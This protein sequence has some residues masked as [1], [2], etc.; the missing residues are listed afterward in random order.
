MTEPKQKYEPLSEAGLSE[1]EARLAVVAPKEPYTREIF[2]FIATI[3]AQQQEIGRLRSWRREAIP[4]LQVARK[5]AWQVGA[6]FDVIAI[7]NLITGKED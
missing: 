5:G 2:R 1:I 7:D 4:Y 3:R 6:M